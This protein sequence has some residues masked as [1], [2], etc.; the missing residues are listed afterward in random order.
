M[1][2][3]GLQASIVGLAGVHEALGSGMVGVGADILGQ[4]GLGA[5]GRA[6]GV[7]FQ[8]AIVG[9]GACVDIAGRVGGVLELHGHG[10]FT[11]GAG[12][13]IHGQAHVG[14][15]GLGVHGGQGAMLVLDGGGYVSLAGGGRGVIL[16]QSPGLRLVAVP[17]SDIQVA[18]GVIPRVFG[19]HALCVGG[20]GA[21][22]VFGQ[23]AVCVG[24][25]LLR[26]SLGERVKV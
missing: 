12:L 4:G 21:R 1:G 6:L 11:R 9:Q 26:A 3:E 13:G 8:W 15:G 23:H 5:S 20:S 2:V 25:D 24:I 19:Q 18:L 14:Q 22:A 10:G 7:A 16:M 17:A